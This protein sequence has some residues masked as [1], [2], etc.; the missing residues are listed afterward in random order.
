VA[1]ILVADDNS[2]IQ[3]MVAGTDAAFSLPAAKVHKASLRTQGGS[4]KSIRARANGHS[5]SVLRKAST[6]RRPMIRKASMRATRARR[7]S[8]A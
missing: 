3:K 6:T 7:S 4:R 8:R 5:K 2:N 1:R